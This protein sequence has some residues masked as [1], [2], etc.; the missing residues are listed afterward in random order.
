MTYS[1]LTGVTRGTAPSARAFHG[2]TSANGR[3][4]VF[5]GDMRT[6]SAAVISNE[7]FQLDLESMTWTSLVSLVSAPT[8]RYGH[9]FA[10]ANGRVFAHAGY[11]ASGEPACLLWDRQWGTGVSSESLAA[12]FQASNR[13][14]QA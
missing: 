7:I 13:S 2:F 4:F 11:S 1:N 8:G 10:S 6:A 9:G 12:D 14:R 3:L 5:G